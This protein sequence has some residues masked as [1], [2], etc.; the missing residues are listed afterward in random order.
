VTD[1]LL[2]MIVDDTAE[3]MTAAVAHSRREFATVRTGRAS[4][5]LV[6]RLTVEA[7]GVEMRMQELA[8]FSV[9][10]ARQLLITP[11]DPA[12]VPVIERAINQADLGLAPS[13]DGRTVRLVFPELTEER[14]R[15][16]VR[17]VNGMAEE[18]KNQL[19]GLRRH[20]RK[21]LDDVAEGGGV[22][23]DDVKWVADQIDELIHKHEAKVEQARSAKED[24]LL[25]V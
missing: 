7:Y 16:L 10:E 20:A 23:K 18:G 19:R 21:D 14:R 9:P 5:S 2:K 13:T 12:N 24:E 17:M 8:S 22:S 4:S 6:E 3:K 25:E 15:D 1:D 11:H